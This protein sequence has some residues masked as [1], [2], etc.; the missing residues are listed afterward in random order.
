VQGATGSI[1]LFRNNESRYTNAATLYRT[2]LKY[3]EL[4]VP[5]G[6]RQELLH[7]TLLG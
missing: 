7:L 2:R 5:F 4:R 3:R 6:I 1:F